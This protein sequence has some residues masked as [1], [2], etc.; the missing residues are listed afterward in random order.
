MICLICLCHTPPPSLFPLSFLFLSSSLP[1]HFI[2]IKPMLLTWVYGVICTLIW[3]EV[4]LHNRIIMVVNKFLVLLCLHVQFLLYLLN[5]LY[6]GSQAFFSFTILILPPIPAGGSSRADCVAALLAGIK[7]RQTLKQ[8][9][10]WKL[11]WKDFFFWGITISAQ[12]ENCNSSVWTSTVCT[13]K[14]SP[15]KIS[16]VLH[17]NTSN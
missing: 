16:K 7:P 9:V 15:A 6:L 3:V 2:V 1:S 11:T 10:V 4:S 13:E 17:K 12:A 14:M 5:C 8:D